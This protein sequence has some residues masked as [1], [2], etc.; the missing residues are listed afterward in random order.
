MLSH[1]ILGITVQTKMLF[2]SYL[3]WEATDFPVSSDHL[4]DQDVLTSI[5]YP[6]PHPIWIKP[7]F[8]SQDKP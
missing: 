4:E 3:P 5:Q 2:I 8:L 1:T 6:N 7:Q